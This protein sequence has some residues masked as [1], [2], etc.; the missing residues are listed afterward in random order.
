MDYHKAGCFGDLACKNPPETHL[1]IDAIFTNPPETRHFKD[2]A[3]QNHCKTQRIGRPAFIEPPQSA[4]LW[5]VCI[6][7]KC[8]LHSCILAKRSTSVTLHPSIPMRRDTL[9]S[10]HS[11][12]TATS[13]FRDLAP[14]NPHKMRY[15]G[16]LA[17]TDPSKLHT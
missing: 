7:M 10:F 1:I 8:V 9:M 17:F 3:F 14:M 4:S 16:D 5:G 6:P 13:N 11:A 2:L 12:V 15:F